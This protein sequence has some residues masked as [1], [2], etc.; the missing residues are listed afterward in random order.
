MG[1]TFERNRG[2][3][4]LMKPYWRGLALV[5]VLLIVFA[6]SAPS[7]SAADTR[8]GD[9]VDLGVGEQTT[10]DLYVFGRNVR[11][12]GTVNGDLIV[13]AETVSISGSVKGSV[14]AAVRTLK[15]SGT[16]GNTLR[17]TSGKATISGTVTSDVVAATGSLT[18]TRGAQIGGDVL[19]NGG[20]AV[21]RGSVGGDVRG[22]ADSLTVDSNVAGSVLISARTIS[23]TRNAVIGGD[24]RYASDKA[25]T[26]SSS[27]QVA[28]EVDRTSSFRATGGPE[29]LSALS[30][31][32]VRL[33]IG[34][35]TGLILLLLIPSPMV[36]TADVI[37][38][39]FFGSAAAGIIGWATWPVLAAI[40]AVL[41]V[42]IPIALIGTLL[43]VCF[44]WLSQ[45]FVGLALG[46]FV[47]PK[48]WKQAT[49]GYNILALAIGMILIGAIRSAPVP[50][51][52]VAV[53]A[54]MALIG[55]GGVLIAVH[56][57]TSALRTS[58]GTS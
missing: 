29:L 43:L 35:I 47:L 25:A 41:V 45:I 51:L 53:A 17:L 15:I 16:V 52:S 36:A 54:L 22:S 5:P 30:G 26:V 28:G 18:L 50:Y 9:S 37:R 46:R 57:G 56:S 23:V 55:V 27:A 44:A 12:A 3:G 13:V 19:L 32:L 21:F 49:R 34:L 39:R 38:T 11:I 6:I 58:Q 20:D 10:G 48:S 4:V 14:T 33:L 42:G 40:L 1:T 8:T 2:G 7:A 24:F 31:Q